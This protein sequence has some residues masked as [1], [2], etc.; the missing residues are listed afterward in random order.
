MRSRYSIGI[1]IV[2]AVVLA[3]LTLLYEDS[4]TRTEERYLSERTDEVKHEKTVQTEGTAVGGAEY[5]LA[6]EN[7]YVVVYLADRKTVFEKTSI[8]VSD[9]P[10]KLQE[11]IRK[12]K[13]IP[14]TKTLYGFLENYSS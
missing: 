3:G 13:K 5:Y 2:A 12:K 14:D 9:L 4:Y 7:G 8:Q 10:E 1:F 11:E 6:E